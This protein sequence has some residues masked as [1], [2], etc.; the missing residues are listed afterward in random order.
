MW[1]GPSNWVPIWPIS[2]VTNSSWKTSPLL[3]NGPPDGVPGRTMSQIRAPN[4]G[5][6][7]S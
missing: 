6:S 1:P 7:R 3:P 4:A 2:V 5:M